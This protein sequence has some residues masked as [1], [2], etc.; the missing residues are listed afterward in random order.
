MK[1]VILVLAV[2]FLSSA[3]AQAH[4]HGGMGTNDEQQMPMMQHMMRHGMMMQDMMGMMK[5]MIEVQRKIVEGVKPSEKKALA[6]ELSGMLE[7]MNAMMADMKGMMSQGMMMQGM[8]GNMAS[9]EQ[10]NEEQTVGSQKTLEKS[11][12]GVTAKVS[13]ETTDGN[14]TFKV[15]LETHTV[16][17]EKYKF[18]EIVVLRA[19]GK[20]YK[21]RVK[22]Q[23]GSGHH[24]SAVIEFD[25]PKAKELELVIKDVAGVKERIFKF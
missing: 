19:G 13:L 18:D 12:A 3:T 14:L 22:S 4:M 9:A 24:R 8:M 6:K 1:R 17:L 5:Q 10:K 21:A 2:V 11:E 20:E 23:E 25:N 16:D 15:A 7:K